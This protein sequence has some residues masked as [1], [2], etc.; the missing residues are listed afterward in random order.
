VHF[1]CYNL[2]WIKFRATRSFFFSLTNKIFPS[3]VMFFKFFSHFFLSS[4]LFC[5]NWNFGFYRILVIIIVYSLLLLQNELNTGFTSSFDFH[6]NFSSY[7]FC[8]YKECNFLICLKQLFFILECFL[9]CVCGCITC[10]VVIIILFFHLFLHPWQMCAK[11]HG[12]K[13]FIFCN[14]LCQIHWMNKFIVY[15]VEEIW[16]E[17]EGKTNK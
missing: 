11:K 5:S 2:W 3:I 7:G 4:N 12:R 9:V 13:F 14:S 17:H 8:H 10:N 6:V 15:R 16:R 1:I